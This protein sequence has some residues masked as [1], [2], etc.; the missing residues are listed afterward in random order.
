MFT[1]QGEMVI[2]PLNRNRTLHDRWCETEVGTLECFV[3][4]LIRV[5]VLLALNSTEFITKT[6]SYVEKK[7][8]LIYSTVRVRESRLKNV[9]PRVPQFCLL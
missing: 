1:S 2:L 7:K 6:S 9:E 8:S 5:S 3:M 4:S